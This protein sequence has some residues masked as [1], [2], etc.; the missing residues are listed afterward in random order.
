[1]QRNV[2]H[3]NSKPDLAPFKPVLRQKVLE[4][5]AQWTSFLAAQSRQVLHRGCYVRADGTIP[6]QTVAWLVE[7][8]CKSQKVQYETLFAC[9]TACNGNI[10]DP[11]LITNDE[12]G[13]LFI[14]LLSMDNPTLFRVYN[15]IPEH[16]RNVNPPPERPHKNPRPT[17]QRSLLEPPPVELEVF[18]AC[19]DL[20]SKWR[21]VPTEPKEDELWE[22]SAILVSC[23]TPEEIMD[24]DEKWEGEVRGEQRSSAVVSAVA[25]EAPVSDPES[26]D[27]VA[28]I[29]L[30]GEESD[31]EF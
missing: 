27:D 15:Q 17:P 29:D 19:C 16:Q 2:A 20:C 11:K 9:I 24:Q 21:R 26:G 28:S 8:Y 13:T 30:F 12:A 4:Q 18:W 6:R 25:S 23:D 1:M 7:E 3:F 10:E 31:G 22:C 5:H 14:N